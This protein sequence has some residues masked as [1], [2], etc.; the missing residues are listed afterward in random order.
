M[1]MLLKAAVIA[2]AAVTLTVLGG[3]VAGA[4]RG[5]DGKYY[6]S[7]AYAHKV[8]DIGGWGVAWNYPSQDSADRDAVNKCGGSV[9]CR[10]EVR[11]TDGCASLAQAND[12][13]LMIATGVGSTVADAEQAALNELHKSTI[14]PPAGSSQG[15][16][17]EG[18]I[19]TTQCNG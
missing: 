5:P 4:E 17:D 9:D 1:S 15:L 3:P 2:S 8:E 12:T 6:G 11:W 7:I 10:V 16:H 13:R 19:V 18:H 14:L